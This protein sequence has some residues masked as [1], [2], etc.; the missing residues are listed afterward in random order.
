MASQTFFEFCGK[1]SL[2]SASRPTFFIINRNIVL[3]HSLNPPDVYLFRLRFC[4]FVRIKCQPLEQKSSRISNVDIHHLP[5]IGVRQALHS[6]SP[7]LPVLFIQISLITRTGFRS[8]DILTDPHALHPQVIYRF[9]LSSFLN[10]RKIQRLFSTTT[11]ISP[12]NLKWTS[13]FW[14]RKK[15]EYLPRAAR[16]NG[17]QSAEKITIRNDSI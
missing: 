16:D 15:K 11:S 3:F 6:T 10:V 2:G 13:E 4:V 5:C 12:N 8:D 9:L 7:V 1:L 17:V 14:T